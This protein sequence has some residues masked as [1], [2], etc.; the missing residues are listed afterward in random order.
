MS[1]ADTNPPRRPAEALPRGVLMG[2]AALVGFALLAS[3][4]TRVSDVGAVHMPPAQAVTTLGLYFDDR[5]DGGV[6]VRDAADGR[7]IETVAPGTNGFL[8]ATMRGLVRERL[9]AQIGAGIPFALTRWSDGT[10]SIED[11]GTGRRV[12]LEAFGP[13]NA[14]AFARLLGP[15]AGRP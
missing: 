2:A 7:I 13:D 11:A 3:G 6:D 1:S 9:R 4:F 12:S 8:R 15:G 5:A 10:L 14:Q